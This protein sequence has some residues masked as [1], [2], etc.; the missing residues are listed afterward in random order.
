MIDTK[1]MLATLGAV[2]L[3]AGCG[4]YG[5]LYLPDKGGEVV[6]RPTQTPPETPPPATP[7]AQDNAPNTPPTTDSP[8]GPAN[9]APEVTAPVPKDAADKDKKQPGAPT[10]R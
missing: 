5:D 7:P 10:P 9:P 2:A 1:R 3:L 8:P 6:T 4:Q